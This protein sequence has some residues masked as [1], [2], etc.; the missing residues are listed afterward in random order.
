MRPAFRLDWVS[1]ALLLVV[2]SATEAAAQAP[3]FDGRGWTVGNQ[4]RNARQSVTEYVLPGQTGVT[5]PPAVLAR[6]DEIIQWDGRS[7]SC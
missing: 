4:Q 3:R 7:S 2:V 1:A 5:I 6:A